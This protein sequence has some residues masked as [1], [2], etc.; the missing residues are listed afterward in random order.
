MSHPDKHHEEFS[1][2]RLQAYATLFGCQ[3]STIFR[4]EMLFKKPDERF[5]IDVVVYEQEIQ[6]GKIEVAVTNGMSD[7]RMIDSSDPQSWARRELIQYFSKCTKD[8]ALRLQTMAWLPLFDG[9]LLDSHHSVG[10]LYSAT[11]TTP[12]QN[13]FFLAPIIRSH[14]EF[15]FDVD[16]DKGVFLW[17]VPISDKERA[18]KQKYG[19]DALI[20]RMDAV[21]LPWIF[22]E[23][24][25]PS[26]VE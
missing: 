18:F 25:R 19:S 14:R 16:G 22:D 8:H 2:A 5:R 3:P 23:K 17:H 6:M 7:Q 20:E 4:P 26:L 1:A 11:D 9:F 15:E 12:W 24:N 13:A 21:K 10:K